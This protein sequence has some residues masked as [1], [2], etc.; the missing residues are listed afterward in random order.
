MAETD[1][2]RDEM[3]DLIRMLE[4]H[5]RDVADAYVTGNIFVY[6]ERGEP[7]RRFSPDVF[8]AFGVGK[9]RRRVYKIWEEEH[10]PT[11]VLEV[12]SRRTWLEDEGNKK[13]LCARL[14]VAEY[15]LYAPAQDYWSPSFQ[16]FRLESGAYRPV[17]PD[18]DGGLMSDK[19]GVRL[20][21]E[22]GLIQLYAAESGKRL[23]RSS[24]EHE[25]RL[26]AEE[27]LADAEA[28]I[29]RLRAELRRAGA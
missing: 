23:L 21:V 27:A 13:V 1:L 5:L 4:W 24:E 19:L 22:E 7:G 10:P 26:R 29:D 8:V 9:H 16:G 3:T 14:G 11:V 6:Y 17:I 20:I 18:A 28:E 15:Y 12:S 2:H 25:G